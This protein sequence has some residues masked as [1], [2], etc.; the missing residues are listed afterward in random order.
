MNK[1]DIIIEKAVDLFYREGFARASIRKIS[2]AAGISNAAIYHYFHNKDELLFEVVFSI[3]VELLSILNQI[4]HEVDDPRDALRQMLMKHICL[5]K[6]KRKEIKIF[7][8]DQY[9]LPANLKSICQKQHRE[10]YNIYYGVLKRFV[11]TGK[12][13][14]DDLTVATF[15][16][17]GMVNWCY[18]WFRED[19]RLTIEEVAEKL[20]D[21][22]FHGIL[23]PYEEKP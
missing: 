19:R 2:S 23:I 10:V 3:G 17:F 13:R 4:V 14:A 16:I 11:Q 21:Y 8:E 22:L 1:K 12:L 15:L 18:R 5:M 20:I 6:E 9:Q 7:I